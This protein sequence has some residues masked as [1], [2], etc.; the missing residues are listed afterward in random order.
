MQREGNSQKSIWR[1]EYM[2]KL[3]FKGMLSLMVFLYSATGG[4]LG[5]KMNGVDVLLLTTTGRRSGKQRTVPLMYIMDG[6]AYVITASA[7]G[8]DKHPGWFFNVRNNPQTAIRVKDKQ[9]RVVAEVAGAEKKPEL[10]TR[11]VEVAPNFAG[12]Q[13]RTSR[14]IPMVIL[15]P[16]DES[17]EKRP[18]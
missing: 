4:R 10:W 3:I 18:A 17:G 12:Y 11:L 2:L 6:S 15:H 1:S 13:K 8:A 9:I 7:G 14:E 5:G 16:V